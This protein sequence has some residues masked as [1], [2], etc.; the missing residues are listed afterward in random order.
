M[1]YAWW[2][3]MTASAK[4][5]VGRYEVYAEIAS[6]GM[7]TVH[8]GRQLGH[9]G[10]SRLV[11]IKRLHPHIA[12]DPDFVSMFLDEARLAT[13]IRHANV[14]PTL[15]VVAAAGELILVMDYVHGESLARL[16]ATMATR[17]E[18]VDPHVATTIGIGMLEGLHAAHEAKNERGLAL[19]IVHR[20][21]SPQN[22]LVGVDGAARVFDF[23]IAKAVDRLHTTQD[24]SLKGKI[25][26]M[27][28][29]QLDNAPVDR[30][31]D[32]WAAS[33]VL[34]ELLVGKRLFVAD[35][36]A[37]LIRVIMTKPVPAPSSLGCPLELDAV[38]AR[39]L[40]KDPNERF[41]TAREM[42]VA[43]EE[44]FASAPARTVSK[45]VDDVAKS[46]LDARARLLDA[47]DR[48]AADERPSGSTRGDMNAFL[49]GAMAPAPSDPR[50][51]DPEPTGIERATRIHRDV[52]PSSTSA[53]TE[54]TLRF[55]VL[56]ELAAGGMGRVDLARCA[57]ADA[58]LGLVA[59]KR[60]LPIFAMDPQFVRMFESEARLT[61]AL[62]HPNIVGLVGY[63][64]DEEGLF[65]ATAL[66]WGGSL[67]QLERSRK[68]LGEPPP[69][70]LVPY[71]G[72]RIASALAA[73]HSLTDRSGKLLEVIHR[74]VS[75]G[76]VLVG[77]NG[78]IKLADFG[79]A[80]A[81]AMAS[82]TATGVLKGK[83]HYLAPEYVRGDTID[84]RS[85]LFSL[86]VVLYQLASGTRP[87]DGANDGEV[88]QRILGGAAESL[89]VRAPKLDPA[90]GQIIERL[91]AR[92]PARRAPGG[93]EALAAELLDCLAAR[94]KRLED[95]DAA[96]GIYAERYGAAQLAKI[97]ELD[98]LS[99]DETV[100]TATGP[101]S[102]P[103]STSGRTTLPG[104]SSASAKLL[105]VTLTAPP[106]V[107]LAALKR[108]LPMEGWLPISSGMPRRAGLATTTPA[109]LLVRMPTPAS[110]GAIPVGVMPRVAAAVDPA[111]PRA[112]IAR[113]P[114]AV[115]AA[116]VGLLAILAVAIVAVVVRRNARSAE[117]SQVA[118]VTPVTPSESSSSSDLPPSVGLSPSVAPAPPPRAA[119]S[120]EAAPPLAVAA[121]LAPSAP[122]RPPVVAGAHRKPGRAGAG[123]GP[124]TGAG[125]A[126]AAP[127]RCTSF[128]F[129]YPAC[130]KR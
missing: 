47:I 36:Q 72:A 115:V 76:N 53:S 54:K 51:M 61:G 97:H 32:V 109:P 80:K 4:K 63:G 78:E 70:D 125:P 101:S 89:A 45:W 21:V 111:L 68:R 6:G 73:A 34:W 13:R 23:G 41:S 64:T 116:L 104:P 52:E 25:A 102:M 81:C 124:G 48:G 7:A 96:V 106:S 128:D 105:H 121:A 126:P 28:P 40:A 49:D 39:G 71:I 98:R 1:G 31:T 99:T 18:R 33:V 19:E 44:A 55:S 65:L 94:G 84:S 118:P 120:V 30:R 11:A 37:A 112:A 12:K 74:D 130:L 22:V 56:G 75:L 91:L 127:T 103:G 3:G 69:L 27:S 85:D 20:D 66:V 100:V 24:G 77:V 38:L 8:F 107:S 114:P 93:A 110:L 14:V 58:G 57:D 113:V 88:I 35:S 90:V 108:T 26:Y 5:R 119:T 62:D 50:A 82:N 87:F 59:V 15:D 83:T 9:V 79:V 43:I 16:L 2:S 122:T 29:E 42:A 46:S 92:D 123:Q 67:A 95:V 17:K 129:D 117:S 86:G 60:L 10:F